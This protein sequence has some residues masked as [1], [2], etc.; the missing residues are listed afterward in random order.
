[1]K[2]SFG[3]TAF[4][5]F[6]KVVVAVV[7]LLTLLYIGGTI[8]RRPPQ[9]VGPEEIQRDI[10]E[11]KQKQSG[12][13]HARTVLTADYLSS[14]V[15]ELRPDAT[16]IDAR[17]SFFIPREGPVQPVKNLFR[18]LYLTRRSN[19]P[20][21]EPTLRE[22]DAEHRDA[23]ILV[24]DKS[25]VRVAWADGEP[26]RLTFTPLAV[27][28]A[29]TT[30]KLVKDGVELGAI[31]V[32][33]R[34]VGEEPETIGPVPDLAV[35]PGQ[36]RAH[37]SWGVAAGA[38]ASVDK[39]ELYKSENR[40]RPTLYLTVTVPAGA[41][42]G[43]EFDGVRADGE[44]PLKVAFADRRFA[45]EDPDVPGGV[46]VFYWVKA[47]GA[48]RKGARVEGPMSGSVSV[49]IEEAF[50]ISL[51][52]GSSGDRVFL[53]VS[54]LHKMP[55]GE[56]VKVTKSFVVQPGQQVGWKTAEYFDRTRNLR[57]RDVDFSTGYWVFAVLPNERVP[58]VEREIIQGGK[59][60]GVRQS[61][62]RQQEVL[63]INARGRIKM[64]PTG[65]RGDG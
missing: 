20:E 17:R 26:P 49:E 44:A 14:T 36:G 53:N 63:L 57:L 7:A 25:V 40:E 29:N 22:M 42:D 39:Y 5:W 52:R 47:V 38:N 15:G 62:N 16:S 6:D 31:D 18:P 33:V 30:V 21:P 43:A 45:V 56:G 1:M 13:K 19:G 64:L 59:V 34:V 24:G 8:L 58:G 28:D 35:R 2:A 12:A 60:V 61:E 10:E 46:H 41:Q 9:E 55:S 54:V 3:S 51:G 27:A 48:G 50:E 23:E 4:R 37:V 11:L 65:V 32:A